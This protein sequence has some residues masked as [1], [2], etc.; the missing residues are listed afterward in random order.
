M[1]C[2]SRE[3]VRIIFCMFTVGQRTSRCK[4]WHSASGSIRFP[5]KFRGFATA[6][7]GSQLKRGRTK[8]GSRRR[9]FAYVSDWS[10]EWP[11]RR[12]GLKRMD[13]GQYF[14]VN[15]LF[16]IWLSIPFTQWSYAC[17]KVAI[18]FIFSSSRNRAPSPFLVTACLA[19]PSSTISTSAV[20]LA[21]P[22]LCKSSYIMIKGLE[23]E[24]IERI[25]LLSRYHD[26]KLVV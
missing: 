16:A 25:I 21:D 4:D 14:A 26:R 2:R 12:K 3:P 22:V 10:W 8:E 18:S 23:G 19:S 1:S 13:T 15:M 11:F 17:I 7:L 5:H 20:W 6:D 24:R 9:L